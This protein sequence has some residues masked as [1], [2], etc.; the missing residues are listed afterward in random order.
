MDFE[1]LKLEID[2]SASVEPAPVVS[3]DLRRATR[4]PVDGL[5]QKW[6]WEIAI[7]L[8]CIPL[9]FSLPLGT[10]MREL[11]RAV[12]LISA[13]L[14]AFLTLIYLFK[15]VRF[16]R[17]SSDFTANTARALDQFIWEA[18]M[19][20]ELQISYSIAGCTLLPIALFA[21][22]AGDESGERL[23]GDGF[24]ER[25][26]LL[27]LQG[28]EWLWLILVYLGCMFVLYYMM[29]SWYRRSYN[30]FI[31][32]LEDISRSLWDA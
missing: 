15:T 6:K 17:K 11:P 26:F 8:L 28:L 25:V 3:L 20:I 10:P 19:T 29:D 4:H 14:I 13:T 27:R 30:K 16:L 5:R 24:F 22:L 7:Q 23:Y 12:F 9:L 31:S 18:R 21:L 32:P 1:K 2:E